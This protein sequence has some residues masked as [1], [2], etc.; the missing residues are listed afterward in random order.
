MCTLLAMCIL[1]EPSLARCFCGI[2]V[3]QR[4]TSVSTAWHDVPAYVSASLHQDRHEEEVAGD[5]ARVFMRCPPR[6]LLSFTAQHRHEEQHRAASVAGTVDA[7]SDVCNTQ[8]RCY[9]EYETVSL[10]RSPLG[11]TVTWFA[12]RCWLYSASADVVMRR[13][14]GALLVAMLVVW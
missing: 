12:L 8:A 2:T 14:Y 10:A 3:P 4:W 9:C 1:L 13:V 6:M 5:C 7:N 11:S